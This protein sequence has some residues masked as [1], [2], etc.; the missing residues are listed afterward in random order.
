MSQFSY[1]FTLRILE[2]LPRVINPGPNVLN[3]ALTEPPSVTLPPYGLIVPYEKSPFDWLLE[4]Q[5]NE[6]VGN[7][8]ELDY[9]AVTMY[10]P[11]H[12]IPSQ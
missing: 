2:S 3:S 10:S 1:S 11:L 12:R 5:E 4:R 8:C 7:C 9:V 6:R